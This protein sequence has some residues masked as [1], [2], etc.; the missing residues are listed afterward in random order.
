MSDLLNVAVPE[1]GF[2]PIR[3]IKGSPVPR[4]TVLQNIRDSALFDYPVMEKQPPRDGALVFVAGGP[5]LLDHLDEI[6]A[7]SQAGEYILTSNN[8]H[9]FLVDQGIIPNG[10]LIFDPKKRVAGYVKKPQA[11]TTYYLGATVV[12]EVFECFAGF[13]VVKVLIAYGLEG[14]DDIRLQQELYPAAKPVQLLVGGTMT[15][16]RAIPF[17]CM[18]GYKVIEFY[19]LDSCFGVNSEKLV[20]ED[21]PEYEAALRRVGRTYEDQQTGKKYV[22]DEPENGGFFYAYKKPRPDDIH[23]AEIGSR[24]FLT[25]PA[26]SHQAKQLVYW[27]NRLEG[28]I[29]IAVHG[30]SLSAAVLLGERKRKAYL[31]KT[32]G[33]RRWTEAYGALQLQ[34]YDES[35]DKYGSRGDRNFELV[36]RALLGVYSQTRR[37]LTWLD[38]ACGRGRLAEEITKA[39]AFVT[40]TNYDPFHP[41]WR[42]QPEPGMHDFV[43][44]M[45]VMEHVEEQCVDNTLTYIAQRCRYGAMFAISVHEAKKTLPDGRNAHVTIRTSQWWREKLG[46]HFQIVEQ[47]SNGIGTVLIVAALGAAERLEAERKAA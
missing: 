19:G 35:E 17:A 36:S 29:E 24:R 13:N 44:C 25:S 28:K 15:P 9:D 20:H 26:F 22:I 2:G 14:E 11:A 21:D 32:I 38:Y 41:A 10:C 42:D 18:L 23:I 47:S 7:R 16:L 8:T 34:F 4:E 37:K 12:K 39:L 33:D 40:A 43:T 45:D 30:D 3:D 31:A 46:N 1:G 5:T 6:R 27:M